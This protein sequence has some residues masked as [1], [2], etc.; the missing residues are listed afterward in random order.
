MSPRAARSSVRV[1]AIALGCALIVLG[2]AA[3]DDTPPRVPEGSSSSPSGGVEVLAAA[4]ASGGN[5][6]SLTLAI[7]N[8]AFSVEAQETD[9]EIT[10]R[11]DRTEPEPADSE[12]CASGT[13]V[14]LRAPLDGRTVID[15]STGKPVPERSSD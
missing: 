3:C 9:D 12:D 5:A 8:Q 1:G 10:I 11:V 14:R 6:L 2:V 7:C 4:E 13:I 15:G